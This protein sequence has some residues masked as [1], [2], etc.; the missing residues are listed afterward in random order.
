[1]ASY[2]DNSIESSAAPA[3]VLV[4]AFYKFVALP[5]HKAL[6]AAIVSVC[7]EHG[8]KGTILLAEEG[9]NGTIAG[10]SDAV[11]TVLQLLKTNPELCDLEHKES[12]TGRLPF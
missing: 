2:P 7:L 1:M 9:I 5:N 10:A 8:V 6:R 12:W 3:P 4:A 11:R